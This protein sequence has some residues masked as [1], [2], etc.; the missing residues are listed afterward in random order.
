MLKHDTVKSKFLSFK[1]LLYFIISVFPL[2]FIACGGGTDKIS[3]YDAP[4]D[5]QVQRVASG[6]VQLTWQYRSQSSDIIYIIARREGQGNWNDNYA[7]TTTNERSFFDD[8][9]TNSYIV[10]SYKVKAKETS[11]DSNMESYF[12]IPA[13]Y[14]PDICKPTDLEVI[15]ISQNQLKLSWKDNVTGEEGYRIDKKTGTQN[16]VNSY[17]VL[18][19]NTTEF[20]DEITELYTNITYRVQAFVGNTLSPSNQIE[21]TP[22]ILT[23]SDLSLEQLSQTQISVSWEYFSEQPNSFEI[24]RKIGTNDWSLL[25]RLSGNFKSYVDSPMLE[26][27][28]LSYRVRAIKDTMNSAYSIPQKINFNIDEL[29]SINLPDIGNQVIFRNNFIFIANNYS[30]VQII[31]TAN[32]TSPALSRTISVPGRVMSVD[33]TDNMLYVTNDEGLFQVYDIFQTA[34]PVLLREINIPG[35]GNHVKI[36]DINYKKY[37]L[38]AA[39]NAGV[40]IIDLAHPS[41]P[42]PVVIKTINTSGNSFKI[43]FSENNLYIA[44]S[45]NGFLVYNISDP[46]NPVLVN[47]TTNVGNVNDVFVTDNYIYIAKGDFGVGVFQKNSFNF[48]SDTDTQGFTKSIFVDNRNIYIADNENGFLIVSAV[49]PNNLN[50]LCHLNLETNVN[51]VYLRNKYAYLVTNDNFK[52]IQIRP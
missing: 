12:S 4:Y 24:Q 33:V 50:S 51:S 27:G 18:S 52:I 8:I 41:I 16:W 22:T 30:G 14:F 45:N 15:Q 37:A 13:T 35:Q 46:L 7:Q 20:I 28:T 1:R 49:N 11:E 43:N 6:K 38:V 34:N 9:P 23:P 3:N 17:A 47:H 42:I 32:P 36:V 29:S 31:N 26:A 40:L 5:L 19:N 48:V 39:G 10:Y 2:F 44:D 21:F 25:K